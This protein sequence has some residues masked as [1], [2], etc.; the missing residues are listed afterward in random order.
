[1]WLT[2]IMARRI[3]AMVI[4]ASTLLAMSSETPEY[5][6]P[7]QPP[8]QQDDG[9]AGGGM[10]AKA[11][12]FHPP[13]SYASSDELL[14]ALEKSFE[15]LKDIAAEVY[16][17]KEDPFTQTEARRG[18]FLY[19]RD[20]EKK[21]SRL[22]I[23]FENVIIGTQMR[24]ARTHY[25]FDGIWL[26]ERDEERKQFIK[27]QIVAPGQTFNPL[28]LGE[29]PF[30]LPIGQSKKDVLARFSAELIGLPDEGGFLHGRIAPI[31]VGL[32]LVPRPGLPEAQDFEWVRIYYDRATL[33]P[34]AVDA[35]SPDGV[36]KYV[37]LREV[38]HNQGVD[39]TLLSVETPEGDG[40][41]IDI[42]PWREAR[43]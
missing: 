43:E 15:T 16:Y 20:A 8:G 13:P 9:G 31:A 3:L 41:A 18:T 30:P 19:Q 35:L 5:K 42:R 36:R 32:E 7:T 10:D 34:M 2:V 38:K 24:E 22:A 29:G 33:L 4:T 40:W 27:R 21:S 37:L 28:K 1:M 25:I 23:L 17:R 11:E 39:E 6:A 26:V 14:D 12:A